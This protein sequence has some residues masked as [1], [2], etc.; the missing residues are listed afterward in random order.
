MGTHHK[1]RSTR[2]LEIFC[3]ILIAVALLSGIV[4]FVLP[5]LLA[6]GVVDPI[7]SVETNKEINYKEPRRL[8]IYSDINR[9]RVEIKRVASKLQISEKELIREVYREP[10]HKV[11]DE[12]KTLEEKKETPNNS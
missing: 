9:L 11:R 6:L 3:Y 5:L 4:A 10:V 7:T 1:K 12:N 2:N 8:D